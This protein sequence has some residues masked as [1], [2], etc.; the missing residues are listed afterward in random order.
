[1]FIYFPSFSHFISAQCYSRQMTNLKWQLHLKQR[2]VKLDRQTYAMTKNKDHSCSDVF[3]ACAEYAESQWL[4]YLWSM[5]KTLV[6][7]QTT[8]LCSS[9]PGN[10]RDNDAS[11]FL[12]A[13]PKFFQSE[14]HWE[15][16]LQW[17]YGMQ[18]NNSENATSFL[19]LI[20]QPKYICTGIFLFQTW[21]NLS[22]ILSYQCT[23][24]PLKK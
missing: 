17:R 1:M 6:S 11:S 22:L 23:Q 21:H 15:K 13:I 18:Y 24:G 12:Q 16:K 9:M 2:H 14:K 19:K 10:S 4:G 8:E 3:E 7:R 20:L 5:H